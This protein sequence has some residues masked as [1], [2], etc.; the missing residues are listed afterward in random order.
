MLPPS[1]PAFVVKE[2]L[3]GLD[4]SRLCQS[5]WYWAFLQEDFSILT[6]TPRLLVPP[7]SLSGEVARR[8]RVSI[9][10][11]LLGSPFPA[12][13]SA[14]PCLSL[15]ADLLGSARWAKLGRFLGGL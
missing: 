4:T 7:H 12:K 9:Y 14:L 15:L 5:L 8:P 10:F 13:P 2:T 11:P 6:F 1:F 3:P